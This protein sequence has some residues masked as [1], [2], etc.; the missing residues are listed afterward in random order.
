MIYFRKILLPAALLL[1]SISV[2][3]A[4]QNG[5]DIPGLPEFREMCDSI[6]TYVSKLAYEDKPLYVKSADVQRNKKKKKNAK[7]VLTFCPELCNYP[8]RDGDIER[9]YEIARNNMPGKFAP[10]RKNFSIRCN[11][12]GLEEYKPNYY[13][14]S[15]SRKYVNEHLKYVSS[16]GENQKLVSN[17]SVPSTPEQGLSK[18]HIAIWQSHGCYFEPTLDRWEWQRARLFGTVEDRFTQSFVI[19]FIV[20][21]LENAGA[22]VLMPRERDINPN[23]IIVDND[24]QASGYSENGK[25]SKAPQPGFSKTKEIYFSGENPFRSGTARYTATTKKKSEARLSA[26]WIPNIPERGEYCVYVSYQTMENSPSDA[27]YLVRHQGGETWFSVNQKMCSETWVYLGRFLF[28]KG[29]NSQ[30]GVFLS[31]YS[32]ANNSVI[33]ADAVRFG[34]G[35]GNI[36]RSAKEN[37]SDTTLA[38][39][40]GHAR[41]DEAALYWLQWAGFPQSVYSESDFSNDYKDDIRSRG[42]WVNWIK[43]EMHVP[44]DL[45]FALH[46]DAG[47]RFSDSIVGTL[48]I[49]NSRPRGAT[50]FP[51]GESRMMSRD[52]ADIVQSQVVSDIKHWYGDSW[53]RRGLWDKTYSECSLPEVP[54]MLL[55]L[56]SHQNFW[57]M[58]MGL[59]PN[60]KFV[61]S[62]AIYKGILRYYSYIND[63]KYVVQP[64]PVTDFAA[65][66]AQHDKKW[67][68]ELSWSPVEDDLEPSANAEFYIVYTRVDNGGFDNGT[69][70]NSASARIAI[71]PGHL[72]SFKVVAGNEG[73]ISFP[74]ETLCSA[75]AEKTS[76][77]N[78]KMLIV[79][80]FNNISAPSSFV[81]KDSTYAGFRYDFDP[82]LPFRNEISYCG[83]Q[84]EFDR[85]IPWQD[86]D[87]PGFGASKS[88][89]EYSTVAGNM[90]DFVA[91]H[92]EAALKSGYDIVSSSANAF[93][94]LNTAD[95]SRCNVLDIIFGRKEQINGNLQKKI[96]Q[97]LG[98]GTGLIIS[99]SDL[100]SGIYSSKDSLKIGWLI[101]LTDSKLMT[102]HASEIGKVKGV[103]N[104]LGLNP[105]A[106]YSFFTAPNPTR[107]CV[108]NPDAIFP[109]S[110]G[111]KTIYRYAG[112]NISAGTFRCDS[113]KVVTLGFPIEALATQE[114]IDLLMAEL[115]KLL[116]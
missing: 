97:C 6:G 64:L 63:R 107:Y 80:C 114:E 73:G 39:C 60:F 21:M 8:F 31:N 61:V 104:K 23:E 48:A 43:N 74:S 93:A 29:N 7:L 30:Q 112:N 113:C 71:K 3:A 106:S 9:I 25:W 84:Y 87:D 18:A 72:Y 38:Q 89:Y 35:M 65:S 58:R 115:L 96:T 88:N 20:P 37:A 33:S 76:P 54:S 83:P 100:F 17:L 44:V 53:T 1:I 75:V 26:S 40:S 5:D 102:W 27:R 67:Y 49:Y 86:D 50:Y 66:L 56:L 51:S 15:D 45:S 59:D 77:L 12:R 101:E 36:A 69:K 34:G 16:L 41:F 108:P 99:G 11:R 57:D 85:E 22:V 95:T 98:N 13:S 4:P 78:K 94:F 2:S 79:N 55:E 19:P 103:N 109:A 92:A 62:R 52:Y 90:F 82:G 111:C 42:N 24:I 10:Y 105:S 46:T 28:E 116:E 81:S 32:K 110:K 47:T 14:S 91:S 70:V 68:A